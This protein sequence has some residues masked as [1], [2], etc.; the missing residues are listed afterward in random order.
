MDERDRILKEV[1][2]GIEGLLT[3]SQ[4]QVALANELRAKMLS[5]ARGGIQREEGPGRRGAPPGREIPE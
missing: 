5:L 2:E 4:W 3:L 1:V